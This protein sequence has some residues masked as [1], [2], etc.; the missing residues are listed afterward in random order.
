MSKFRFSKPHRSTE[1]PVSARGNFKKSLRRIG[2]DLFEQIL[3]EETNEEVQNLTDEEF[4][5]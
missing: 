5:D 3:S 2:D 4:I 1:E